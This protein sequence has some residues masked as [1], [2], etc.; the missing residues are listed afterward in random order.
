M[1][2]KKYRLAADKDFTRLFKKGRSFHGNGMSVRLVRN[3]L[4]ESRFAFVVS[5]KVSKKAVVRNKLRRR[6]REMVAKW[7]PDIKSGYDVAVLTKPQA[8]GMTSEELR[9]SL[10]F[11]FKKAQLH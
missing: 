6:L 5:V 11:L 10:E 2:A 4:S 3:S 9:K 1:L 7:I 8:I